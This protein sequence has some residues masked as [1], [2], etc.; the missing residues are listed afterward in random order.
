MSGLSGAIVEARDLTKRYGSRRGVE[1]ISFSVRAGETF[2]FLGPNGAGKTTVIRLLLDLLHPTGGHATLFGLPPGP[3]A[4]ARVGYLPGELGVYGE[5]SGVAWLDHLAGL[6]RDPPRL[7]NQLLERLELSA[8]DLAAPVRAYSRGM[9]QKLALVQAFQH[10]PELLILDEP[11]EGLDPL[12]RERLYGLLRDATK[13]RKTV[14]LSSHVLPEVERV[15]ERVAMV[16]EGKLIVAEQVSSLRNQMLRRLE[17]VTRSPVDPAT[18]R[19]EGVVDVHVEGG[20]ITLFVRGSPVPAL[21]AV[22]R[23]PI[24]DLTFERPRLEEIFLEHY[25][26]GADR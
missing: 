9:R 21:Q 25:R 15:C 1:G 13:R 2:G 22:L 26:P 12:M 3:R 23:L 20:R 19:V 7:R 5:M 24:E 6:Q 18:L 17:V 14:F 11:T 8:I 16:R 10:D 4:M